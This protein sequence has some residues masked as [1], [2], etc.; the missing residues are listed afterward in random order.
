MFA[1]VSVSVSYRG[2]GASQLRGR[3]AV[4]P[5]ATSAARSRRHERDLTTFIAS[6]NVACELVGG[7]TPPMRVGQLL[8][9]V[10]W[11]HDERNPVLAHSALGLQVRS[12]AS[13]V[14]RAWTR[15]VAPLFVVLAG[16]CSVSHPCPNTFID[17]VPVTLNLSTCAANITNL[18]LSG[19]CSSADASPSQAVG[20]PFAPN[21][22][23]ITGTSVKIVSP[24]PGNCHITLTFASGSTYSTDVTFNS[25]MTPASPGCQ[26]SPYTVPTQSTVLVDTPCTTY[27][28][29]GSDAG[30]D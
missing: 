9:S 24:S 2:G 21:W 26:S 1:R 8:P 4:S 5:S 27:F 12:H 29:A 28:D 25:E 30:G 13:A 23:Q 17:D 6:A 10:S 11:P 16:G 22:V 15:L 19:A 3:G 20:D 14:R 18:T 7:Q